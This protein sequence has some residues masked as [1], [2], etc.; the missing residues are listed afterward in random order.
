MTWQCSETLDRIVDMYMIQLFTKK[1]LPLGS[2]TAE[3]LLEDEELIKD[4]FLK[5]CRKKVVA[6]KVQVLVDIRDM[7]DSYVI[8]WCVITQLGTQILL[9]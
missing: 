8:L 2:N 1:H 7:I 9:R 4:C 5:Y 6:Q 3:R